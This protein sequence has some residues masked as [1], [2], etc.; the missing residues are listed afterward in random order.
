MHLAI[1]YDNIEEKTLHFFL[2]NQHGDVIEIKCSNF[3][4]SFQPKSNKGLKM[5]SSN[6]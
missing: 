6:F 3:T 4:E 1:D 5:M 2:Y